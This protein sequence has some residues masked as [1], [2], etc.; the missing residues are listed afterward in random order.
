MVSQ[1][2]SGGIL[3]SLLFQ[4]MFHST[5]TRC[6]RVAVLKLLQMLLAPHLE[7]GSPVAQHPANGGS[8][9]SSRNDH[10]NATTQ[11]QGQAG[12][13]AQL[14]GQAGSQE[15]VDVVAGEQKE[16][17]STGQAFPGSKSVGPEQHHMKL[18]TMVLETLPCVL[19][20]A[21]CSSSSDTESNSD[22]PAQSDAPQAQVAE[23][24]GQQEQQ[25][26]EA[27]VADANGMH[28]LLLLILHV[29]TDYGLQGMLCILAFPTAL[30]PILPQLLASPQVSCARTA[31][32]SLVLACITPWSS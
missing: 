15:T 19:E 31:S 20:R 8:S 23:H 16:A 13:S 29:A 4:Y 26:A 6:L 18:F 32:V 17:R 1:L 10:A 22:A 27:G 9:S 24:Q 12:S 21:F 11:L 30:E 28:A 25:D 5:A 7:L 3:E 2:T 14:Q